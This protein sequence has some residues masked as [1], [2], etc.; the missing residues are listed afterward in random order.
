MK[1]YPEVSSSRG[2]SR[3]ISSALIR[4]HVHVNFENE[5]TGCTLLHIGHVCE[6]EI[7]CMCVC[8]VDVTCFSKIMVLF[9]P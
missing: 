7:V 8:V 6:R 1:H 9:F 3:L 2:E 5:T 4:G